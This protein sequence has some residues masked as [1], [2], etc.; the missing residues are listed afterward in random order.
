M[1]H[2]TGE[3]YASEAK[4]SKVANG[5]TYFSIGSKNPKRRGDTYVMPGFYYPHSAQTPEEMKANA[6]LIAAAP[7]LLEMLEE[8]Q[9]CIE[10]AINATPTGMF[11]NTLT[12][13][14]IKVLTAI[15]KATA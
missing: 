3:W 8:A 11:R 1:K 12:E 10:I 14:N 9:T 7:E 6:K 4:I 13:L 2:T 5:Q 15:N